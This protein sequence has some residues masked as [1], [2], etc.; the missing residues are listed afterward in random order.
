MSTVTLDIDD[1][2]SEFGAYYLNNGQNQSRIKDL[3][4]SATDTS[5]YF[6]LMLT[7]ETVYNSSVSDIGEVLQGYQDTFTPKGDVSFAPVQIPLFQQKID[8]EKNPNSIQASWLGFLAGEGIDPAQWPFIKWLIEKKL[9]PRFKADQEKEAVY[10]GVHVA[11]TP[12]TPTSAKHAMNGIAYIINSFIDE[13]RTSTITTGAL[14]ATASTFIGQIEQFVKD[15]P[16]EYINDVDYIFMDISKEKL[17]KTAKRAKYNTSY[18]QEEL[19]TI[20]DYEHIKVVGLQSMGT[21]DKIWASTPANRVRLQKRSKNIGTFKVESAKR[22][23]SVLTDWW[24][25]YGFLVPELIFTNNQEL[26]VP[27]S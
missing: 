27:V 21:T 18:A 23:V 12:G 15:I 26:T 1:V 2:V 24:E 19:N 6:G 13:G 3:T 5:K 8:W 4:Y 25:G 11:A 9:V 20:A 7:E 22:V 14:S 10:K 16:T 17:Y